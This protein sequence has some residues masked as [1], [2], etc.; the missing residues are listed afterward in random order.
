M[1]SIAFYKKK[2]KTPVGH[3]KSLFWQV[4]GQ[5][6]A[7]RRA[8]PSFHP[9]APPMGRKNNKVKFKMLFKYSRQWCGWLCSVQ[10]PVRGAPRPEASRVSTTKAKW[11]TT[12]AVTETDLESRPPVV[13]VPVRTGSHLAGRG[14]VT[15]VFI[16][17]ILRSLHCALA[18]CAVYCNRSWRCLQRADSVSG[19]PAGGVCYHDNSKFRPSIFTKLGL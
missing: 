13:E 9:L 11:S 10:W 12:I 16:S 2:L 15:R 4:G 7:G 5:P 14:F 1:T 19:G 8:L 17:P 3:L 18:S 6:G